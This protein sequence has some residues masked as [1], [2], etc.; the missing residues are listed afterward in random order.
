MSKIELILQGVK[1]GPLYVCPW[2]SI[3]LIGYRVLSDLRHDGI[4][5]DKELL[6][7]PLLDIFNEMKRKWLEKGYNSRYRMVHSDL[8]IDPT[9]RYYHGW[10]S[11]SHTTFIHE[12]GNELRPFAEGF[13]ISLREIESTS[14]NAV[15]IAVF[16]RA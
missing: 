9:R 13:A 3:H 1:A 10:V 4:Y 6:S 2:Q 16:V 7:I 8:V 5:S 15:S 14:L 11:E 12:N